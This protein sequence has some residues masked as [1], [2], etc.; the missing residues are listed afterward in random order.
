MPDQVTQASLP[1]PAG[2]DMLVTITARTSLRRRVVEVDQDEAIQPD[3]PVELAEE[4]IDGPGLVE[5]DPRAPGM[6]R[7]QAEAEAP[8]RDAEGGRGRGDPGELGHAGADRPTA[9]GRVLEDDHCAA[10]VVTDRLQGAR[11]RSRRPPDPG[12]G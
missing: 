4:P 6:G 1:D 12:A 10:R 5:P 8:L 2:A 9:T 3:P 7:V 11:H